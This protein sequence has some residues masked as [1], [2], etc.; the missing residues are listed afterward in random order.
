MHP[1][2]PIFTRGRQVFII[3]KDLQGRIILSRKSAYPPGIYRLVGGGVHTGESPMQAAT[4]ELA[5]ELNIH[6]TEDQ[7][8]CR[9]QIHY[10]ITGQDH[11]QYIA[12]ICTYK[13]PVQELSVHS[14]LAAL[15]PFTHHQLTRLIRR[16]QELSQDLAA[17]DH[18]A[19]FRWSDYGKVFS[20]LHQLLFQIKP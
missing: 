4:R 20:H 17:Y 10:R 15:H 11:Y 13:S 16:Y 14:E 7:L 3:L 18:Q 1:V 19:A 8:Q 12:D 2:P 6:A 5:E 9:T